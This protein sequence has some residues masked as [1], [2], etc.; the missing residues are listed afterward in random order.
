MFRLDSS[1]LPRYSDFAAACERGLASF[2]PLRPGAEPDEHGWLFKSG[3]PP[4]YGAFGRMRFLTTVNDVLD[5]EPDSFFEVAAGDGSLAATVADTGCRASA[6]DLRA[7]MLSAAL[8]T[9]TTG[10]DVRTYGG[11]FLELDPN[12]TG[13]FDVVAA[14]E[15]IEHVA[16][17]DEFLAHLRR[18]LNPGG[19]IFLTTPN[20]AFFRNKLPTFDEVDDFAALEASQ[21]QP[22]ADGHLFLFTPR[23]LYDLAV[24]SGYEVEHLSVWGTPLLTG[25]CGL[26]RFSSKLMTRGAYAMERVIQKTPLRQT[27]CTAI[28]AVLR[29]RVE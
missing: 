21:F 9:F 29:R 22:D 1:K 28:T 2:R 17:P 8:S 26:A 20:G 10:D 7:E 25:N 3:Y 18:F 15:V 16:H 13:R 27:L 5:L 14:C 6:N 4:S 24:V 19:R 12:Q 11:N 23:E